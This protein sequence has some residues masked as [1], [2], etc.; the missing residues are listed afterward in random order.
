MSCNFV[1]GQLIIPV[2]FKSLVMLHLL[3]HPVL[4]FVLAQGGCYY[5]T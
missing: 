4:Q 1:L 5:T 2:N 3:I